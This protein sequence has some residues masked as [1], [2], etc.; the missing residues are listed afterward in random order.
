MSVKIPVLDWAI[1]NKPRQPGS[2]DGFPELRFDTCMGGPLMVVWTI[3]RVNPALHP[4]EL[5][6]E[7]VSA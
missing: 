6:T 2:D 3:P 7:E 1:R 4:A 5:E